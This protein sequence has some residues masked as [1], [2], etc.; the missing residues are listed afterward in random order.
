MKKIT[1]R[2][3]LIKAVVVLFTATVFC[4]PQ[5]KPKNIIFLIGDGMGVNYVTASVLNM[6]N[7]AFK[8]FKNIGL[9][10]TCSADALVTDSAAGATA[11]ACGYKSYNGAISVDMDKQQLQTIMEY[12]QT[13][14]YATGIV[15]TC[16]VTHATPACFVSH[17]ESRGMEFEIAEQISTSNID[18][19][20]GGGTNFFLPEGNGG[21]R[22]D[23]K[24][25]VEEMKSKGYQYIDD[26]ELLKSYDGSQKLLALLAP[27]GIERGTDRNY[28][29][30]QMTEAAL[31]RLSQNEN[32][33]FLM[34]EGSQIDWSGHAND[35]K[36]CESEMK[37]FNTAVHAALD[38]AE[39][40]GNTLV[41][42][43]ADHET[44]GLAIT[45]GEKDRSSLE[46]EYVSGNHT[47][48]MVGIYSY[49]PGSEKFTGIMENNMISRH[50][51]EF[52][53]PKKKW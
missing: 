44:G 33:F 32:G 53:E 19:A 50:F 1:L 28:T 9:S 16:Q 17:V 35:Y 51:F 34:V 47:A 11:L 18:I 12:L 37:D 26:P 41:V 2:I 5:S 30:G 15:V 21:K 27:A 14:N 22:T 25:I 7:D 36:Y 3:L 40:D 42:V 20:I 13:K 38:F 24:N 31:K 49:G 23:D 45:G 39:K 29:L 52:F 4:N 8:R 46:I 48:M 6:E 43:T 10:V